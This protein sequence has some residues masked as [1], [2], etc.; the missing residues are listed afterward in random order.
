MQCNDNREDTRKINLSVF[1]ICEMCYTWGDRGQAASQVVIILVSAL[2]PRRL[3]VSPRRWWQPFLSSQVF[4]LLHLLLWLYH[5]KYFWILLII[6]LV[7]STRT[8]FIF[9]GV[10]AFFIAENR[11]KRRISKWM[12]SGKVSCN[13]RWI[14]ILQS[15]VKYSIISKKYSRITYN[16]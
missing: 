14:R 3:S 12:R 13:A 1:M 8:S 7:Y 16:K 10:R 15:G 2:P 5:I 11:E 6:F 4:P 9:K